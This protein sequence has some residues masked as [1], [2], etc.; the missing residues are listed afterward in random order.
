MK[1]ETE[2][3]LI[4]PWTID[5]AE[6][7]FHLTR[8]DGFTA[9]PITDYR[10]TSVASAEAWIKAN[11]GKYAVFSRASGKVVGMGGLTPW[12]WDGENL[13]DLT[14]RLA[15]TEQGQ[16]YGMELATAL[17]KY[18]FEVMR[19]D[20]LTATITPDNTLSKR[21]AEKLGM[22]FDRRIEL[23]G[24]ATDLYRLKAPDSKG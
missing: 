3:L 1:I 11:K 22:K 10:Q 18:A 4:K 17:V 15:S 5:L 24:V 6:V 8:D 13:I 19:L 21:L 23:Y 20:Q 14:Y 12:Q 2:R 7:F 16:G 9:Y